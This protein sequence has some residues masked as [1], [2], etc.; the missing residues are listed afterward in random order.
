MYMGI[1]WWGN[2]FNNS[3]NLSQTSN[4]DYVSLC[5]ND[6]ISFL[7]VT[8][9]TGEK[10]LAKNFSAKSFHVGMKHGSKKFNQIL[11]LFLR[12]YMEIA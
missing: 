3:L 11:T 12:E 2:C 10:Y 7:I 9:L 1:L 8:L 6:V 5:R 4:N